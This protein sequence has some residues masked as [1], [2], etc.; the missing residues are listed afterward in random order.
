MNLTLYTKAAKE[1]KN[2]LGQVETPEVKASER[3][4]IGI[5]RLELDFDRGVF[6]IHYK[7]AAGQSSHE[8]G[9]LS[10]LTKDGLLG[11][12]LDLGQH[13]GLGTASDRMADKA[14]AGS[15][16]VSGM[17]PAKPSQHIPPATNVTS[18]KSTK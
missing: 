12:L 18:S 11:D 3:T 15:M 1:V 7:N 2:S 4:I 6:F 17:D 8:E 14:A 5:G 10:L 9:E 13:K 16:H